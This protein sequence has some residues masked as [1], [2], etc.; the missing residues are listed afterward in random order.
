[1][2]T[3]GCFTNSVKNHFQSGYGN[4]LWRCTL[5]GNP[6]FLWRVLK[7]QPALSLPKGVGLLD[8]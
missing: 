5:I 1:M 6:L 4:V 7:Q 8:H 2:P 3:S